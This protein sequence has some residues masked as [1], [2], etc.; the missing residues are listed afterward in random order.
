MITRSRK[1]SL[2]LVYQLTHKTII[3]RSKW[4]PLNRSS[5]GTNHCIS[6]SSTATHAFAPEPSAES[7]AKRVQGLI[8]EGATAAVGPLVEMIENLS[9]Q[10]RRYDDQIERLGE[11]KYTQT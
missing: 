11:K 6:S 1:L 5:I 7:F 2:K 4:R 3:C 9:L 8:P 10:I